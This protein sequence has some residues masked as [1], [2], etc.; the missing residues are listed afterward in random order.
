M[1]D[2]GPTDPWDVFPAHLR[3]RIDI[4]PRVLGGEPRVRGTRIAV[5]HVLSAAMEGGKAEVLRRY[6]TLTEEDI[7]AAWAFAR[8]VLER[9]GI[10]ADLLWSFSSTPT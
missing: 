3:A 4:D 9:P 6:P 1:R 10:G 8:T 5:V 7:Q 2:A